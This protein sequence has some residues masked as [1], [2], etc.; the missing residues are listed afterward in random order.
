M[1]AQLADSR[2]NV[3]TDHAY[4]RWNPRA[5]NRPATRIN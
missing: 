3:M 5:R 1:R 4:R 2:D